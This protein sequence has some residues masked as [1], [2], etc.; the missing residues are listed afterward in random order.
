MKHFRPTAFARTGAAAVAAAVVLVAACDT[1]AS[2]TP[3]EQKWGFV[4][5]GAL[6]TAAGE[7]RTAPTAAFFRGSV[8]SIPNSA[9]RSDSCFAVGDYVAPTNVFSGVTYL[10]AGASVSA[11]IGGVATELP[12]AAS[13]G[14]TGYGL[15]SGTSIGYRPGDSVVVKVPGVAGGYP[16]SE[17]RSRTAESFT[18]Q[19]ISP[20]ANAT[21]PLRWTQATDG[22]SSLIVSLQYTPPGATARTQEIRCAFTDDGIDSIPARQHAAWS[23]TTNVSRVVVVTRLRTALVAIDGGALELI[24]TFQVPTPRP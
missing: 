9:T 15:A 4:N 14:T 12:R 23:A 5:V 6:M 7:F 18:I 22:N 17:V 1:S 19:P 8:S 10:D 2:F 16:V 13:G 21:I 3:G 24:S 20:T 11:T